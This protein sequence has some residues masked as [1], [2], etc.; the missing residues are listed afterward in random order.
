MYN[1]RQL[2]TSAATLSTAVSAAYLGYRYL[3]RTP[4]I[5]VDKIG[6]PYAHLMRDGILN[7]PPISTHYCETLI[8]GSG[9]A[10][11]SA[12]WF[13]VKNGQR[14]FL[15]AEGF[16]RNGNNAA[17]Q[18]G[19]LSAPTGAHYLALPS[20]ES[21]YVQT[22]LR[23]LNL[24][25]EQGF[26]HDEDLVNVPS[27]RLYYKQRWQEGFLP[28]TDADSHRFLALVQRLKI[29]RGSDGRKLFAIPIVL[30]SQDNQ[31][32]QLDS[33][34]FSQW[35]AQNNF[36]SSTLLWYLDYC[37]R[38]DYGQGINEVSAFA[39]LHYFAA[40]GNRYETVLTWSDGLNRISEKMRQ[41]MHLQT[42]TNLPKEKFWHFQQPGCYFA[43]A[44]SVR[45]NNDAVSVLLYDIKRKKNFEIIAKKV[46]CATPLN[47]ASRIISNAPHYGFDQ[48]IPLLEH[49]PW[50]VGNFVLHQFPQENKNSELAWD[51]VVFGSKGL[52]W[53]VATHQG[54]RTAKPA[55][56]IFTSYAALNYA[57]PAEVR[58]QLLNA[59]ERELLDMAAMDLLHVYGKRFWR[60]VDHIALSVRAHAMSVPQ[61]G[62]LN[63]HVLN[64]VRNHRSRLVFAHSDLSGYSVFEEAVYWGAQ[65]AE[66]LL[67]RV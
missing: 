66:A 57:S 18:N 64:A 10:A 30:S 45:E 52:G 7:Q 31:W 49:A 27:E 26:Y 14:D 32:R 53:V 47:V 28:A 38:D 1:R 55:R 50:L 19:D 58:R 29:A 3:N 25:S 24:V 2:L 36:R 22:I 67:C 4:S 16:E 8:L 17:Y 21:H 42:L 60:Y 40:R 54:M 6:L 9:A 44:V 39:G 51:N 13:L 65:A 33:L 62:Y 34:T 41:S 61:V 11:L 48:H 56:T 20:A 46:I 35:L 37:C 43:A 12:A 59:N 63:H 5:H 15:V 23:D